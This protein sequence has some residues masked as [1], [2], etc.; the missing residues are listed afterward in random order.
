MKSDKKAIMT[1]LGKVVNVLFAALLG[2]VALLFF[3]LAVNYKS[4]KFIADNYLALVWSAAVLAVIVIVLYVVFFLL[5]KKDVVQAF[6]LRIGVRG[7]FCR[8]ILCRLRNGDN[9]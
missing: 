9:R 2:G 5:G 3:I 7:Y 1:V 4:L 6:V 8:H